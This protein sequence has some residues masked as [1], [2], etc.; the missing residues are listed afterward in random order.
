MAFYELK[1]FLGKANKTTSNLSAHEPPGIQAKESL[2][3]CDLLI[4]LIFFQVQ[5]K[6]K[7]HEQ[8][9]H[10]AYSDRPFLSPEGAHTVSYDLGEPGLFQTINLPLEYQVF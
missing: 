9:N 1:R 8:E 4:L 5:Q 10:T 3:S 2:V 7:P 6:A